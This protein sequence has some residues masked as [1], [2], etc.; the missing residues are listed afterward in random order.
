VPESPLLPE[1]VTGEELDAEAR[2]ELRTL[3]RD[4]A[5]KVARHLVMAGRLV[6]DDPETA[7]RHAQEARRLAS[8]VGIVREAA[9]LAAYHAGEWSEALAE[10]RAARRLRNTEEAYLPIL[11]DCERGLGRPE[12]ALDLAKSPAADK[13]EQADRIELKI[14]ESGARRDLGQRDAAVVTLQIPELRDKRLR[15]WSARLFY[16][17]ADALLE[18]GRENEASEWFA[19]AAAADRDGET[20]AAERYAELE[21]LEII[22]VED[23]GVQDEQDREPGADPAERPDADAPTES[24]GTPQAAVHPGETDTP[25]EISETDPIGKTGVEDTAAETASA[26]TGQAGTVGESGEVAAPTGISEVGTVGEPGGV[27]AP[28]GTGQAGTA[29]ESGEVAVSTGSGVEGPA[30]EVASTGT[31]QAG[32]AGE[33]GGVV[34]S[35]G[36]GEAGTVGESGE[37]IASTGTGGESTAGEARAAGRS[38]GD[39]NATAAVEVSREDGSEAAGVT[40]GASQD[41]ASEADT[42]GAGGAP[43]SLEGADAEPSG[44]A[45][46]LAGED[47][48]SKDGTDSSDI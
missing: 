11:A 44:A 17:Y 8:R 14:V 7:Y 42:E 24:D 32:T 28:T 21:G 39:E 1:E 20:D 26:G 36:I 35:T 38:K 45:M 13:L 19:R 4:L 18:A 37:V 3:P 6:D 31:G 33:S 5:T 22:D 25:T 41:G 27:A 9:G 43:V 16:A 29:G 47:R 10:L 2:V 15:P 34:A 23:D 48:E 40:A 30:V 46:P 12:R